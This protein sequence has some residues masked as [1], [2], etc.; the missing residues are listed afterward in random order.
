MNLFFRKLGLGP[1]VIIV[2]GL[3]GSSDNWLTVGRQLAEH[4]FEVFMLDQR[5]HGNSP[6]SPI[7]NYEA[8]KQDLLQFIDFQQ[9]KKAILIG[10]SMGGK[11]VI[12]FALDYPERVTSLVVVDIAPKKYFEINKNQSDLSHDFIINTLLSLHLQDFNS[13]EQISDFVSKSIPSASLR[14]FLL[15]NIRRKKYSENNSINTTIFEWSLNLQALND[16]LEIIL[17][18]VN[19][20]EIAEN[21]KLNII[22]FPVLFIRGNNSTHIENED[23]PLIRK[24]FPAAEFVSIPNAGHWVHVEQTEL[25]MKN[26]LYFLEN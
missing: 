25:F 18:S 5:N 16:N 9:I 19:F 13:R 2:H 4:G 12:S 7:H 20:G 26:L 21:Q 10:H 11:T 8:M 1:A 23:I 14:N 22:G 15:K 3:Y 24:V 17:N 6:H